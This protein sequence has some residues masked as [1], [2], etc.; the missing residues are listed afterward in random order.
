MTVRDVASA[1][2]Q[3]SPPVGVTGVSLYLGHPLA[4]WIMY[5]T[6]VYLVCQFIVIAPKVWRTIRGKEQ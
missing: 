6:G 5:G 3:V 2:A 1:A 4:D